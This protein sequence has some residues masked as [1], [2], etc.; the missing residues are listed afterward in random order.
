[1]PTAKIESRA[2]LRG[3][4]VHPVL[5][6]FPIAAL[7]MLLGTDIAY[8]WTE[9]YFWARAGLWLA[10][11]GTGFGALS[12]VAGA[13]DL[14]TV[15]PIRRLVTAWAHG[16]L[17]VMLLSLAAFNLML[18]WGDDPS[19][20]IMPWG[21]YISGLTALLINATGVLGG[22]LVYEYGVGVDIDEA[23][24]RDVKP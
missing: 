19:A 4:P 13:I 18:R 10:A 3:H 8:V 14:F 6:H 2:T 16:I 7:V 15:G 21:L 22:H 20:L 5:I 12:G 1:M 9:D 23:T 17:A 11:I 24:G